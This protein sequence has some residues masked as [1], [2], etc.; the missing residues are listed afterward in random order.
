MDL[1]SLY[2]RIAW[3]AFGVAGGIAVV[4]YAPS[5]ASTETLA[6]SVRDNPASW[7]PA[8]AVYVRTRSSGG[9]GSFRLGN[10][11]HSCRASGAAEHGQGVTN[12]RP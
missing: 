9:S 8:Y 2:I 7:R 5:S 6:P 1:L 4:G 10:P 11:G 3:L 12:I